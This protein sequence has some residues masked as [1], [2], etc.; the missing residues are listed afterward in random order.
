MSLDSITLGGFV[1]VCAAT[2]TGCASGEIFLWQYNSP[3]AMAGYTPL[4]ATAGALPPPASSSS[5]SAPRGMWAIDRPNALASL[6]NWGQ[7]QAVRTTLAVASVGVLGSQDC[8]KPQKSTYDI[9]LR[10]CDDQVLTGNGFL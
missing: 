2:C 10:V 3:Q 5:F 1:N 7:P 4:P 6:G 9:I 8:F